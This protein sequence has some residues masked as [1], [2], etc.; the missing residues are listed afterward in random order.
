MENMGQNI[1]SKVDTRSERQ[2]A[3]NLLIDSKEEIQIQ[4]ES[5]VLW[6]CE[7]TLLKDS[8]LIVNPIGIPPDMRPHEAVIVTFSIGQEK[9]FL[10]TTFH[11]QGHDFYYLNIDNILYRLQRRSSFRVSIPIGYGARVTI[12]DVNGTAA[13]IK[14]PLAD[15]SAGGFAFETTSHMDIKLSKSDKIKGFITVGGKFG[16]PFEGIVR[17]IASYGSKGSGLTRLGVEFDNMSQLDKEA[18]MKVT[19]ELHRDMFSTFKIASR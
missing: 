5:K 1:F 19:M 6:Q 4:F 16:K 9:Y 13:N 14:L 10:K 18:F 8:R 3:Y 2:R 11:K 12:E 17:H 15:L 7:P